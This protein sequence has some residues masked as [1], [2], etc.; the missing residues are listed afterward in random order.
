MEGTGATAYRVPP[1]L[2]LL[3]RL[4]GISE[5][6]FRHVV[7]TWHRGAR[8]RPK[9]GR[10]Q[11]CQAVLRGSKQRA[12]Q[13][14]SVREPT[15]S[16]SPLSLLTH[17]RSPRHRCSVSRKS[18]YV[19]RR[20]RCYALYLHVMHRGCLYSIRQ[21]RFYDIENSKF[22]YGD[23]GEYKKPVRSAGTGPPQYSLTRWC[24]HLPLT[25]C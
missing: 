17:P 25:I 6:A 9:L 7:H 22:S 1:P 21:C 16:P 20:K 15:H 4:A 10:L 19:S 23:E 2:L 18:P 24:C 14:P 11:V 3:P 12:C 5:I 8:A 13:T